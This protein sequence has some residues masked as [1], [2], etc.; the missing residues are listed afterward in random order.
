MGKARPSGSNAPQDNDS[1]KSINFILPATDRFSPDDSRSPIEDLSAIPGSPADQSPQLT[2][3]SPTGN[4]A[5]PQQI[6]VADLQPPQPSTTAVI[7]PRITRPLAATGA[8]SSPTA[9]PAGRASP[10]HIPGWLF[11]LC[12]LAF[13]L[14]VAGIFEYTYFNSGA[15]KKESAAGTGPVLASP[16]NTNG[17]ATAGTMTFQVGAHPLIVITGNSGSVNVHDGSA[18]TVIVRTSS[19]GLEPAAN[20]TQSHDSQGHDLITIVTEPGIANVNY[21][22]TIPLSAQIHVTINSGSIAVDGAAGAT[23]ASQSGSIAIYNVQGPV[24]ARTVSGDIAAYTVTGQTAIET[25]NGSLTISGV[26][27]QLQ[28]ITQ[29]GDV[30]VSATILSGQSVLQTNYGS[31]H[32]TGSIDPR[33]TYTMKTLSGDVDLTLPANAAFQLAATTN[34]GSVQNAFGSNT[35]G[36]PPRAQVTITVGSGSITVNKASL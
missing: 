6:T 31:I 5:N 21:D 20:Y 9:K 23:V 11:I 10:R 15:P 25:E 18:G 22:V 33:G 7:Q 30:S 28:A 36:N 16:T 26:K 27:G 12:L 35:V 34:S 19:A 13:V 17:Q 2:L 3:P 4:T 29:N 1:V 24:D 32:F 8:A 14:L